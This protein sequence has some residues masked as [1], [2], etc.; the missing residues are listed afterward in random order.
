MPKETVYGEQHAFDPADKNPA[1]PRAEVIWNREGGYVQIVT[2]A[3]DANGGRLVGDDEPTHFTD[4]LYV[5]LDRS[6][7]NALIR[8]LRRA[9]DQAFGRDE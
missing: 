5:D 7:I 8:N 6:A 3:T 1:V 4:G 2:K 9:R